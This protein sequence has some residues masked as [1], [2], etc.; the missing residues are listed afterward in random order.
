LRYRTRTEIITDILRAL[1]RGSA[2]KT[3][4]MHDTFLSFSQ[5]QDFL[6]YLV[7][8]R[9]VNLDRR[10]SRYTLSERGME[11]VDVAEGAENL[12]ALAPFD[13]VGA[14]F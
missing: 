12:I 3:K 1:S 14:F 4:L 9:L 10:Y 2:T 11:L 5:A 7:E 8:K 13:K 6:S